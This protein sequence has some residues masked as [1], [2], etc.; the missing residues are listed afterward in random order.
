M[1]YQLTIV[2]HPSQKEYCRSW[3]G[4]CM[5]NGN[6]QRHRETPILRKTEETVSVYVTKKTKQTKTRED[7]TSLHINEWFRENRS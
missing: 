1:K 3:G 4:L 2:T 6:N 7:M 5:S